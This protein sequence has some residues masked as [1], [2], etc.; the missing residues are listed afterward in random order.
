M[1]A[2]ETE[3]LVPLQAGGLFPARTKA[4][5]Y[6]IRP[7]VSVTFDLT[8]EDGSVVVNHVVVS[9]IGTWQRVGG[10]DQ[11]VPTGAPITPDAVHRLP[12]AELLDA[13][14]AGASNTAG[15]LLSLDQLKRSRRGGWD[16]DRVAEIVRSE[17]TP[18]FREAVADE[19]DV[20]LRT[21]SRMIAKA[22]KEGK[23]P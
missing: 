9:R 5:V 12:L 23:L 16:L 3:D 7:S 21:A 14:I 20:S 2:N 22:K 15:H 18:A 10:R 8:V 19:F 11:F 17:P 6:S 4:T 13:A 1:I